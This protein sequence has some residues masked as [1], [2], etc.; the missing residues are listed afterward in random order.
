LLVFR[1]RSTF[2][3]F[4]DLI[5]LYIPPPKQFRCEFRAANCEPPQS[6]TTKNNKNSMS[7]AEDALATIRDAGLAHPGGALLECFIWEA[8]DKQQAAR[9]LLE[10]C[11]PG[12]GNGRLAAFLDDW[13]RLISAC[14]LARLSY[15][16]A[17]C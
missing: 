4:F 16:L 13:M 3:D 5:F 10:K 7:T 8:V 1:A 12:Q 9:Y 11:P 6:N 14:K 15:S 17:P 2:L